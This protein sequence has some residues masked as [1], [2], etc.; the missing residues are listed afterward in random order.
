MHRTTSGS[1]LNAL[2][3]EAHPSAVVIG[4]IAVVQGCIMTLV[5]RERISA[6]L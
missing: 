4:V 5:E 3:M 6:R 2:Y 1:S